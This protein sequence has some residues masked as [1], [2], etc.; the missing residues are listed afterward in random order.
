MNCQLRETA[1]AGIL[2]NKYRETAPINSPEQWR[3]RLLAS[4]AFVLRAAGESCRAQETTQAVPSS[5]KGGTSVS[6][7]FFTT[8]FSACVGSL[9]GADGVGCSASDT[10][11]GGPQ[12]MGVVRG[13]GFSGFFFDHCR[14]GA[15]DKVVRLPTK[16]RLCE[17]AGTSEMRLLKPL[18]SLLLP[19]WRLPYREGPPVVCR[20]HW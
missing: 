1:S 9:S 8:C 20:R 2:F 19:L 4:M 7:G 17:T 5:S 3:R 6:I 16:C 14:G 10:Q 12:R 13:V 15:S 18:R 11:G